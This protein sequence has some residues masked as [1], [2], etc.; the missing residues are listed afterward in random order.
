MKRKS[1][2]LSFGKNQT[3]FPPFWVL[4]AKFQN[5]EK[6]FFAYIY[7]KGQNSLFSIFQKLDIFFSLNISV[8]VYVVGYWYSISWLCGT[9]RSI[10]FIVMFENWNLWFSL[11]LIYGV[12]IMCKWDSMYFF[13][14]IV[15]R[16]HFPHF[17]INQSL[18]TQSL[19]LNVWMIYHYT[20]SFTRLEWLPLIQWLSQVKASDGQ[21]I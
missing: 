9:I 3:T 21:F 18:L 17:H 2:F 15:H 8:H 20:H 19:G 6:T 5:E 16:R 14:L 12:W 13:I 4:F 1:T 7:R 11:W 10:R